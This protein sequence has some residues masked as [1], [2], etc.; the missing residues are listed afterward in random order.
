MNAR[1]GRQPRGHG[2][3]CH[4]LRAQPGG[5]SSGEVLVLA[6][7]DQPAAVLAELDLRLIRDQR[8]QEPVLRGFRPELYRF[9]NP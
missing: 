2:G 8:R 4:L 1:R 3:G 7:D 9:R 6:P 5:R